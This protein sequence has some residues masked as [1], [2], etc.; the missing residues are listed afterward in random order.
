[1]W[2]PQSF[3]I[4]VST[5]C[6]VLRHHSNSIYVDLCNVYAVVMLSKRYRT[7]WLLSIPDNPDK[8]FPTN[9]SH[10]VLLVE[11]WE[12]PDTFP[13][14]KGNKARTIHAYTNAP[15][16]ELFVNGKSQG[17]R[18]VTLMR[19]AAGSYAEWLNVTWEPGN[20][21]AVA[22][23]SPSGAALASTSRFTNSNATRLEVS[24]D[25]P[26]PLTGTGKAVYL[27]GHDA[28]LVRATIVD[29]NGR[30]SH[31]A[32][33]NITFRVVSGPGYIQGTGNGDPHCHEPNNAPWHSAYHGLVRAVVR[34]SSA[35]GLSSHE[36]GLLSQI[37]KSGLVVDGSSDDIN[38][39]PIVVEATAAGFAPARLSIPTS[40]DPA[41][42]VLAVAE[43]AA[44]KPVYFFPQ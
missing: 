15:Y 37:D 2:I 14:T 11:S 7:Q 42:N 23:Q 10:E 4:L 40:T 30:T 6:V 17:D 18:A 32:T 8:T 9:G 28:A 16:V 20:L 25:A 24:L 27:D 26:S 44:G 5:V 35:A 36:R 12:S 38:S 1:M 3:G 31:M 33:D 22:R 13:Q 19:N 29:S 21:T 34:V 41:D 43:A 39:A